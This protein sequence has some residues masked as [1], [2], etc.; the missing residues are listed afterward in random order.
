MKMKISK[1]FEQVVL[2]FLGLLECTVN[3]NLIVT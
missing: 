3:N 1:V 2:N